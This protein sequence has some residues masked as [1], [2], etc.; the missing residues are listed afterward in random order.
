MNCKQ[1][2]E[3]LE[4]LLA[5]KLS[6]Q[7]A[8]DVRVHLAS[9]VHCAAELNA[10][11]WAEVLPALDETI[12]PSQDF[13]RQFYAKLRAR[14]EPWWKKIMAWGWPRQ[15]AATGTLAALI[16]A[17]FF[18]V[19][20]PYSVQNR[21]ASLN[22]FAVAETLPLLEDMPVVSNLDLLEDFDTIEDLPRLM[23]QGV[24]N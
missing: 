16:L 8:R 1:A 19:R 21:A 22:D 14:P 3:F 17:G 5:G 13:A 9:C 18:V 10:E 24:D 4:L 11:Q 12:E 6:G 7:D 15:L 2:R 20:Y 23:N